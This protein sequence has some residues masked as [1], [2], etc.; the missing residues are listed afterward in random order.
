M[1]KRSLPTREAVSRL[2]HPE[3]W[4]RVNEDFE[5]SLREKVDT[6]SEFRIALPS[7]TVKHVQAIRHPVLNE[8][9]DVAQLVGTVLDLTDRKRAEEERRRHLWFLESLD[10]INRAMQGSSDLERMLSDVLDT[11]LSIFACDRAWLVYP[12]DPEAASWKVPMEHTRPEFP[13]AFALGLE[14]PVA[15]EIAQVFQAVRAS[16]GPVRFGPGSASPLPPETARRF[17]IQS[18]LG[19]A[20]Y[21]KGDRPYMLGLHQCSGPRVWTPQ[22]ER[23]FQETG[24]RLA[25]ALTSVLILRSLRESERRLEEAQRIAHVG[26]WDRDLDAGHITLSDEGARIFGLQ[27]E[28]RVVDLTVWHERWQTLIH[29]EDRPRA[30]AAAAAALAGG[31]RYDVEYRVV[32]RT[33]EV[34]IVHSQGDVIRDESGRPC[35][36]FG[37]MQDITDRKR[38]EEAAAGGRGALSHARA[39]LLRRVLGER[40]AASLHPPG[41]RRRARGRAG[42]GL[43]DRQDAL[44]VALPRA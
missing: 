37:I 32:H 8:A 26:Y 3:D 25:D 2:I 42:A 27:P 24:R 17:S 38:A 5:T 23:L 31:P 43:G 35:R 11:V 4:D 1:R 10:R 41:V 19:M 44:G 34:R 28:D 20:I 6:S 39:I 15:P 30:A 9:G 14:L 22:E 21:P 33:G 18:M 13:G 16:S 36:M 40:R 7:G 12:C 29:P